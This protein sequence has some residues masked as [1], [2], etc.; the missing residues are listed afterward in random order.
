MKS[1]KNFEKVLMTRLDSIEQKLDSIRTEAI[2][3]LRTKYA[4][5]KESTSQTAKIITGVGGAITLAIS[6][7]I[8]W[9][10]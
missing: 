5:L 2:P 9:F 8:A 10:K 1:Q 4:V 6:A 3:E 7:A